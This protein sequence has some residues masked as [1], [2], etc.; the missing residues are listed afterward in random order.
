MERRL[1]SVCARAKPSLSAPS[2]LAPDEM[3]SWMYP[4]RG[5]LKIN[6]NA[7]WKKCTREGSAGVVCR[8]ENGCFK[9]ARNIHL[10]Y[11]KGAVVA[12]AMAIREGLEF[13][14]EN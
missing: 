10:P 4:P 7:G 13:A 8:D 5:W 9:G 1:Y 3:G 2:S 6:T 11:S 12:E 14:I